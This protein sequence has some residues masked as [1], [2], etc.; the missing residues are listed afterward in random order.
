MISNFLIALFF[1]INIFLLFCFSVSPDHVKLSRQI[2]YFQPIPLFITRYLKNHWLIYKN[3]IKGTINLDKF[4]SE[5]KIN[6]NRYCIVVKV[7]YIPHAK[8]VAET[9]I[10]CKEK[11]VQRGFQ[12]CKT[13]PLWLLYFAC[14]RNNKDWIGV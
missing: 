12:S 6:K 9:K 10:L 5:Y 4:M 7:C 8:M 3:S 11:K 14:F 13:I 1:K 2:K